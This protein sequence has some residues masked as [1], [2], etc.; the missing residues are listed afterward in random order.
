[1]SGPAILR[2]EKLTKRFLPRR[3]ILRSGDGVLAVDDVSIDVEKGTTLGIVGESGSGKTT[4]G[5]MIV[6]LTTPTSGR[7]LLDGEDA[8]GIN[9]RTLHKRVQYVFQDPYSSLNPRQ[10]IGQSIAVP[11]YHLAGEDRSRR[12]EHVSEL[13]ELSGLRL[14]LIDRYPHEL[15][16]GQRQRV[17][18]ARAIATHPDVLVLDEPVSALD[19]S[20]QAQIL[21]LLRNIQQEFGLTYLFISHDLAVV[22]SLCDRVAVMRQGEIVESGSRRE[23][24]ESPQHPYTHRLLA[25]VPGAPQSNGSISD[26]EAN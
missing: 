4:L 6:G 21:A 26:S 2:T 18:I 11:L 12:R 14:E 8:A 3:S 19:V 13:M 17:V 22:E 1:M 9:R 15:S 25:A 7:T 16:G 10:T 24:F 5:R 20:I 23:I